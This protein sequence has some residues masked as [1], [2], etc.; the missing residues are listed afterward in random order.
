[1][2]FDKGRRGEA[3]LGPGKKSSIYMS[4]EMLGLIEQVQ[5]WSGC[6][7]KAEA[8]LIPLREYVNQR[9]E[10][11]KGMERIKLAG[12]FEEVKTVEK[13][14]FTGRW[15]IPMDTPLACDGGLVRYAA[16]LSE[17]GNWV[18]LQWGPPD[19]HQDDFSAY[20]R[21]KSY[22]SIER[23]RTDQGIGAEIVDHLFGLYEEKEW[24][25]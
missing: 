13:R 25:I 3:N 2:I 8:I 1:M 7:T 9:R 18:L 17:R 21:V 20:P 5:K 6:K 24:E 10:L 19:W 23:M 14:V 4:A 22:P 15:I 16:A 11:P 12:Y